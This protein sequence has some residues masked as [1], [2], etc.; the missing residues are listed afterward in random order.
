LRRG[1]ANKPLPS[2][3]G[4]GAGGEGR[5][6]ETLLLHC[7]AGPSI[8]RAYVTIPDGAGYKVDK[9]IPILDGAKKN[10]WFRPVDVRTAPDGSIF[11]TDWYDPGV[12]GHAQK[13]IDRGRI[14]RVAPPGVKYNVPKADF[15]TIEGNI[16]AL[17]SPCSA[18]RYLAW[19][20][21]HKMGAKAEPALLKMFNESKVPHERARALWLLGRIDG[22]GKHYVD[23]TMKDNDTNIRIVGIRLARQIGL[24]AVAVVWAAKKQHTLD[25]VLKHLLLRGYEA[26]V[27]RECAIALRGSKGQQAAYQWNRLATYALISR[28]RWYLEALG[29]GAEGNWDH[30]MGTFQKLEKNLSAQEI[31]IPN[32]RESIEQLKRDIVWRS[33]A[34]STPSLL[35]EIVLDQATPANELP[36]MFRAFDFQKDSDIK[37]EAL[38]KLAFGDYAD[39]ERR[40]FITSEAIARLKNFD[41]NKNPKHAEAVNKMLDQARNTSLFV[42]MVGKF[43]VVERYPELLAIAQNQPGE[44]LGVDAMKLLLERNAKLA[45]PG[46]THKDIKAAVAT[47]EA[48]G[49]SGQ[50]NG[51]ALL[52]PIIHDPNADL[53]LR[54]QATRALARNQ[55][56]ARELIKLAQSK[57]L[58][59]DLE[60]AAGSALSVSTAKDIR[61]AAEK[62]FPQPQTKD[63]KPLPS[64]TDLVKARGNVGNGALVFAKQGT[65]AN[66]HVVN[67]QGKEV[68]PNL[69]EIGK[70]LSR[71]A[72]FESILYPSASISHNF[73]MYIVETKAGTTANGVLVSKTPAEVSIKGAD[74]IVR[75]FKTAEVESVVRSPI[76]L[77]PADLH[78]GMTTQEM[79]DLVEY[80]LTLREARK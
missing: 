55:V 78:Q 23:T 17:K 35:T 66:C 56:G 10:P 19:T 2:P 27:F 71:E 33:R 73:E 38:V 69:S 24:D 75:T 54:R 59:K 12:G 40:K 62:L 53:E 7:D 16:E 18:T 25:G 32:V 39:P 67:G 20:N 44:Q 22:K 11:V 65:C 37:N 42:E 76:S 70:K 77:M 4:R 30:C 52:L 79:V 36:R 41:I 57:Q 34:S 50:V 64:I 47:V 3:P 8:L 13:D 63:K 1:G 14:F 72:V 43:N 49:N 21:L 80:L 5:P 15:S 31:G 68:G 60:I 48:I 29:I 74:A 26:G 46:L 45:L 28:D 9:I 51:N 58:A 61:V 6:T